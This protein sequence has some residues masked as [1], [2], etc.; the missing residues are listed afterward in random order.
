MWVALSVGGAFGNALWT[1]LAKPVIQDI[2]PLRMML[3]FRLLLSA[4][5]LIP[6][7]WIREL[8]SNPAFWALL[9]AIGVLNGARWVIIMHGVRR[10]YF[11]TYGMYNTAPLFTLL[12]APTMLPEHFGPAVWLGVLAVMGGGVAFYRTSRFSGFG[13]AGAVLTAAVNILCKQGLNQ[14]SPIVFLFLVQVSSAAVLAAGYLIGNGGHVGNP[15][16]ARDVRRIAP[17]TLISVFAGIFF[18]NA[19]ALDTATRVTAVVRVNLVFGFLLSYLMLRET[20]DWQ[21]K[22]LGTVL[23]VAGTVAVAL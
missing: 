8:P 9:G 22:A 14:V 4:I 6:F 18:I 13:L 5:L 11:A 21:W 15:G 3:I 23:I 16:W 2:P 12:L 17:L 19:L 10:D 1:A 7:L 20:W